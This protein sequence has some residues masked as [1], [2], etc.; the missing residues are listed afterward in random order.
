MTRLDR[1]LQ[2]WRIRKA[3]QHV[4]G[5]PRI[6]DIG[7]ADGALFRELGGGW[8]AAVGI[9][10]NAAE[11]SIPG[12]R[13][14]RGRF[15][16]DLPP[17]AGPFDV[18]TL[19][20]TL[21]HFGESDQRRVVNACASVLDAGGTVIAS[22]PSRWV[23]PI[24]DVL[25]SLRLIDGMSLEEHHGFDPRAVPPLF[26]AAGFECV[27]RRRFQLGLNNLFVFRKPSSGSRSRVASN[28]PAVNA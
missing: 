6:L 11:T 5:A 20:A 3:L 17:D 7:C 10:P 21:E 8:S 27:V 9:D 28:T 24:L 18:V 15:P 2:K 4:A 16:D 12:T 25:K 13:M 26:S 19:L 22:V 1:I 14:V 23:D